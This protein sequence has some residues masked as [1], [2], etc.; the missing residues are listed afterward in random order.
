MLDVAFA[1]SWPAVAVPA[2]VSRGRCAWTPV[3]DG[4]GGAEE[5][6][7]ALVEGRAVGAVIDGQC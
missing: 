7:D 2:C 6:T 1:A 3:A 4:Q 5:V